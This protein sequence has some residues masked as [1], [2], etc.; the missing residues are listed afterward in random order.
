[1]SEQQLSTTSKTC[2]HLEKFN[3]FL[4]FADQQGHR[5]TS[6]IKGLFKTNQNTNITVNRVAHQ[7]KKN[8]EKLENR[9]I[10]FQ[11]Q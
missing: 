5:R 9:L 3:F 1:M 7:K 2:M 11:Q 4:V 8:F 10:E 6:T